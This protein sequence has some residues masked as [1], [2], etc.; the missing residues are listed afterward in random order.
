MERAKQGVTWSG[1][2]GEMGGHWEAS[3]VVPE[4]DDGGSA[5]GGR[6]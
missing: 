4:G 1:F 6:S 3:A 5:Q 2:G